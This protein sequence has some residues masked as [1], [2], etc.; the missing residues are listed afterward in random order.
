MED[1]LK[2]LKVEYIGNRWFNL[3]EPIQSQLLNGMKTTFKEELKKIK[4]EYL[5]NQW[6]DLPQ[7]LNLI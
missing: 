1:D 4:V 7:I 2:I 5:S 6:S 3:R